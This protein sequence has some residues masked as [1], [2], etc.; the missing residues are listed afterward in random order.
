MPSASTSRFWAAE[1]TN[2][3][4]AE[5]NAFQDSGP[6]ASRAAAALARL[7]VCGPEAQNSR[8][9]QDE[10][11]A[12]SEEKLSLTVPASADSAVTD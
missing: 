11:A 12:E 8:K 10:A 6:P 3:P 9:L 5:Q 1:V 2:Q 7:E 4:R